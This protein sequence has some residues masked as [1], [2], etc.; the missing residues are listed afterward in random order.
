MGVQKNKT[1]KHK[2]Q[3]RRQRGGG[4][5][6]LDYIFGINDSKKADESTSSGSSWFSLQSFSFFGSKT[7]TT[8]TNQDK[9]VETDGNTTVETNQDKPVK[10]EDTTDTPESDR[11]TTKS[12]TTEEEKTESDNQLGGKRRRK[13]KRK[14]HKS[15]RKHRKS[16]HK[17]T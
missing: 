12:D 10:T 13:S 14:H 6:F 1:R 7:E 16:K 17:N 9:T 5:S 4:G 2:R 15:K 3:M 8:E 11:D